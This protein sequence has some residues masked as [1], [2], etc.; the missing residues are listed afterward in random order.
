MRIVAQRL[1]QPPDLH[2]DGA[3]GYFGV[4]AHR[5]VDQLRAGQRPSR[6]TSQSGEQCEFARGQGQGLTVVCHRHRRKVDRE[7][8]DGYDL[9]AQHRAVGAEPAQHGIDP[10][11]QFARGEGLG[12]IIVG[13][14]FQAQNPVHAYYWFHRFSHTVRWLWATHAVYHSASEF[15]LPAAVRLGWTGL[16]SLG[17]LIYLPLILTGFPPLMVATL[18]AANLLYQYTLHTEAIDRLGPLELVLNTPSHHR[19]HHASDVPFLDCNFG[20][21]L[22]IYDRLFGTFRR[23]SDGGGLTYGL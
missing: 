12:E 17:W 5:P 8:P 22:I 11:H 2:V 23:E 14:H 3:V 6:A 18:L 10:R 21:M 15:T 1:A 4:A 13:A 16:F 20:G 9:V 19:A 7:R